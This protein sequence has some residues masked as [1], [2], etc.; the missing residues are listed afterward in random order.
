MKLLKALCLASLYQGHDRIKG[1]YE[2]QKQ[3][4]LRNTR[5]DRPKS[6]QIPRN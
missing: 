3:I 2:K 4:D 1:D 5:E 6:S